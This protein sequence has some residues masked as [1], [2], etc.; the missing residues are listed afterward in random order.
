MALK[1]NAN[2]E[3]VIKTKEEAVR[4]LE[5]MQRLQDDYNEIR[6][7]H[8]LEELE[9]DMTELK[10][11]A[12]RYCTEKDI[13]SLDIPE[14]GKIAKLVRAVN[15]KRWV[16]TKAEIKAD[17]PEGVKPLRSLVSK[18]VWMEITTRVPDPAKIDE[19]VAEGTITAKEIM[20]AYVETFK[21]PY[22]L[23]NDSKE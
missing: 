20:P 7:E 5:M 22:L 11:A 21:A 18:E 4:A 15:T 19:A 1:R 16:G 13:Q 12:T 17:D 23:I 14:A 9:M 10:K 2:G 6:K 8:G 3:F